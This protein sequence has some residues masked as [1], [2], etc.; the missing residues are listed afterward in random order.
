[1]E[2]MEF[3]ENDE[4]DSPPTTPIQLFEDTTPNNPTQCLTHLFTKDTII[5][6]LG[7]IILSMTISLI[8]LMSMPIARKDVDIVNQVLLLSYTLGRNHTIVGV[9]TIFV[10]SDS[11]QCVWLNQSTMFGN[12]SYHVL[13]SL[14][15]TGMSYQEFFI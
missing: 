3:Q 15:P 2:S 12:C 14:I 9:R 10:Y 7:S 8:Y 13:N 4:E 11:V 1:M 5:R 6:W